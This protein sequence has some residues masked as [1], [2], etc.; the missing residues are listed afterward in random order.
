MLF[1]LFCKRAPKLSRLSLSG[2]RCRSIDGRAIRITAF[3]ATVERAVV[4][5]VERRIRLQ[6]QNQ[7]WICKRKTTGGCYFSNTRTDFYRD[8]RSR[9]IFSIHQQ[10]GLPPASDPSQQLFVAGMS[11]A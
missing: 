4:G 6:S 1:C 10:R 3:T 7:V 2:D 8:I 5:F 11:E 9:P